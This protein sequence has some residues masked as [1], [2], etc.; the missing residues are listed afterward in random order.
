MV[1]EAAGAGTCHKAADPYRPATRPSM[2]FKLDRQWKEWLDAS[3]ARTRRAYCVASR[4]GPLARQPGRPDSRRTVT[5]RES[6]GV[7]E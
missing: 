6:G 2:V 1:A 7:R 5:G 4:S 3:G